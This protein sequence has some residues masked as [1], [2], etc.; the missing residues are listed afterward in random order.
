MN[1]RLGKDDRLHRDTDLARVIRHG[2]C[3]GDA[4][5]VLNALANELGRSRMAVLVT[6]RHGSAVQ[7]NRL[8]R[9]CREAFRLIR[10]ELPA[11]RDY[12]IRPRVGCRTSLAELQ[13]SIRKLAQIAAQEGGKKP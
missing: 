12:T 1:Q 2:R 10:Q 9:L 5:L 11:G 13:A 3:A 6:R 4:L 7:R 8:K